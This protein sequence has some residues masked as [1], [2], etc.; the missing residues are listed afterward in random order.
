MT[1]NTLQT[2]NLTLLAEGTLSQLAN[3]EGT[4]YEHEVQ[5]GSQMVF[6][7]K[8]P[9]P[10]GWLGDVFGAE[11][12]A[13]RLYGSG[14]HVTDVSAEGLWDVTVYIEGYYV[15]S[16]VNSTVAQEALD[17]LAAQGTVLP[18]ILWPIAIIVISVAAVAL[19][20][21]TGN[22]LAKLFAAIAEV[23]PPI[24]NAIIDIMPIMIMM[25]MMGMISPMMSSSQGT[26]QREPEYYQEPEYNERPAPAVVITEE[27]VWDG[28]EYVWGTVRR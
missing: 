10:A 6:E 2:S 12:F 15:E 26:V 17:K 5:N 3:G 19:T 28:Y 18:E 23:I 7:L 20:I 25:M 8:V 16:E 27:W 21:L 11:W 22:T 14:F 1:M 13:Q 4:L 9:A 24:S